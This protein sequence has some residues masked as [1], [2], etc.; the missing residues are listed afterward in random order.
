MNSILASVLKTRFT[1]KHSLDILIY[2][3]RD[4]VA[5]EEWKRGPVADFTAQPANQKNFGGLYENAKPQ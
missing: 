1:G 2:R 4:I 5:Q 3:T